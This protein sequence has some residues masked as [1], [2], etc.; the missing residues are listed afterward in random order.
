MSREPVC[1]DPSPRRSLIVPLTCSPPR[2]PADTASKHLVDL[3]LPTRRA[4]RVYFVVVAALVIAAPFLPTRPGLAVG[5]VA[6]F[7][8]SAWCLANFWRCR[9]AHCIV[10]GAGWGALFALEIVEL[11]VGR[12]LIHG[13]ESSVF[14]GILV[15]GL[16]FECGWQVAFG[17]NAVSRRQPA[18]EG[19]E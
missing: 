13:S 10:T 8:G 1:T 14:V 19:R 2:L 11:G 18:Q 3:V 6:S 15:I 17:T 9:E 7:A 5:A 12:S 4:E 16:L